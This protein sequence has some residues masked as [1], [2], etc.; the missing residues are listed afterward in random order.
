M[1]DAETGRSSVDELLDKFG[2]GQRGFD[3]TKLDVNGD[4]LPDNALVFSC[5][6]DNFTGLIW[7]VKQP[8]TI[9]QH[10]ALRGADNY[11]SW[12][13]TQAAGASCPS[14]SDCGVETFIEEV[15]SATYCGGANWRL[16]SYQE[17]L[18]IMDYSALDSGYLLDRDLFPNKADPVTLGHLFHWVSDTYAGGGG[19]SFHWVLDLQTGDDSAIRVSVPDMAYVI[20]V[21]TP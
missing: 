9:P 7:E 18:G 2:V 5:V 8:E 21:R 20:L 12:D 14:T 6:R 13:D 16:P 1:Q 11:Y 3:F 4:E 19:E 15:N 10:T 17:L